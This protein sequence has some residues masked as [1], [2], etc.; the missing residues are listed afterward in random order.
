MSKSIKKSNRFEFEIIESPS[1]TLVNNYE[2]M[3]TSYKTSDN[4]PLNMIETTL[5]HYFTNNATIIHKYAPNILL[6]RIKVENIFNAP[7]VNWRQNR[8]PDLVRIPEIANYIETKM[9]PIETIIYISFN[10]KRQ[11]FDIIDGT[12]RLSAIKY[13]KD[14]NTSI[15][16]NLE[17]QIFGVNSLQW[18]YDSEIILNIRFNCDIGDLINL[19]DTLNKSQ[20]MPTVLLDDSTPDKQCR[21]SVIQT[22]AQEWQMKYVKNFSSSNDESYLQSIGSTNKDKFIMLLGAIYDKYNI[23]ISRINLI[24]QVL[25]EANNKMKVLVTNTSLGSSK[26]RVKCKDSGCYLFIYRNEKLEKFI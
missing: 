16:T 20:S 9:K 5:K 21:N 2:L 10:N 22:I 12:H 3:R 6:V 25:E 19:R 23:D 7:I 11:E 24:R 26:A 18:L 4:I 17:G 14:N 13:L 15:S 8:D 1:P